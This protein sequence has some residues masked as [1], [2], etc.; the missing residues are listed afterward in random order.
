ML[1]TR[2]CD[3]F[4]L[5]VP[6]LQA[7]GLA[8]DHP[9]ARRR[10]V[11]GRRAGLARRALHVGGRAGGG[12]SRR[13]GGSPAARSSSTTWSP[14]STR[15][16]S[17][18]R[19][20]RGR[21][22]CRSPP[23]IPATS[24]AGPTRR[25]R[26][27]SSR[28]TRSPRR[29]TRPRAG[30]TSSSRR[31]ARQAGRGWSPGA[32]VMALVPQVVDAVAPLPVLAAGAVGDGRGLAAALALGAAG[33]E[34]R[35]A[36]PRLRRGRHRRRLEGAARRRGV[37]GRRP[38]RAVDGHHAARPVGRTTSCRGPFA[39]R[40]S[41]RGAPV[42][43]RSP[44]TRTSSARRSSPRSRGGRPH[45]VTPFAGQSVGLVRDVRPAAAIVRAMAAEAEEAL[46]RVSPRPTAG[47]PAPRA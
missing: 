14:R 37:R 24:S 47:A 17:R 19:S 15:T 27:S 6:I 16:P 41:T 8:R 10:R 1:H 30:R 4:D 32:S 28:S 42:P 38:V 34:R 40:S 21:R 31:A 25:R 45:D 29:V 39:R 12:R 11:R 44:S 13:S 46:A 20:P 3:L 22:R 2:F 7:A 5:E 23:A 26:S 43:A 9:A 18:P 33:C 35:D 36:L